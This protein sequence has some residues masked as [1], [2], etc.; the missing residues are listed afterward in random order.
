MPCCQI[1]NVIPYCRIKKILINKIIIRF[2]ILCAILIFPKIKGDCF[3]GSQLC[4]KNGWL[5]CL[6]SEGLITILPV[7]IGKSLSLQ[8]IVLKPLIL[9][10]DLIGLFTFLDKSNGGKLPFLHPIR[11]IIGKRRIRQDHICIHLLIFAAISWITA[12]H[13]FCLRLCSQTILIF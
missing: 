10:N 11:P 6:I 5:I 9:I 7:L 3:P 1:K 8:S 13:I 4:Q 2:H 12:F